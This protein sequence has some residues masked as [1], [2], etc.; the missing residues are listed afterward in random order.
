MALVKLWLNLVNLVK[1]NKIPLSL[2]P[3]LGLTNFSPFGYFQPVLGSV[4][5]PPFACRMSKKNPDIYTWSLS[6]K[7]ITN[8]SIK[9]KKKNY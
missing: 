1:L 9:P 2:R 5:L 7:K 3:G 4:G 6:F 8:R